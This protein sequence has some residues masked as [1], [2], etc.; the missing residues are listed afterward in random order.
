MDE[1][2]YQRTIIK[3]LRFLSFSVLFGVSYYFLFFLS[4]TLMGAIYPNDWNAVIFGLW[5][6]YFSPVVF[7]LAVFL[8][9]RWI[10]MKETPPAPLGNCPECGKS[11]EPD[12]KFCGEC[13]FK[14]KE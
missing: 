11:I 8:F 13:G 5:A 6:I 10:F 1:D 2:T 14:V 7:I 4:V 9:R 3:V 12:K